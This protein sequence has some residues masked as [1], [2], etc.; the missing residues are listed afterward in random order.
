[1]GDDPDAAA[2]PDAPA[3]VPDGRAR[4][5]GGLATS[6]GAPPGSGPSSTGT[7]YSTTTGGRIG[8]CGAG[9]PARRSSSASTLCSRERR[10]P[11]QAA[12][13]YDYDARFALE[14]Q[15]TNPALASRRRA[16]RALRRAEAAGS[17]GRPARADRGSGVVPARRRAQ[18][19]RRRRG[20]RGRVALLRRGGGLLVLGPRSGFKDRD[21]R[22]A[23]A[24]AAGLARRAGGTRGVGHRQLPR[25]PHG[26]IEGVES[27]AAGAFHGWF[28]ELSLEGRPSVYR[29][30]DT[31]FAGAAAV[32]V[33]AVGAGR[34]VY[35][36][37][38]AT[39]ETLDGLYR[40]LAREAAL[41]VFDVPDGRGA[42]E[43]AQAGI[44][45]GAAGSCSITPTR[46]ATIS[47]PGDAREPPRRRA[48]GRLAR[49]RAYGVAL[50][51][52]ATLVPSIAR[53]RSSQAR[54]RS[55]RSARSASRAPGSST[56]ARTMS[57]TRCRSSAASAASVG[58]GA[59]PRQ[60]RRKFA[61]CACCGS[62]HG[63]SG[64]TRCGSAPPASRVDL[65]PARA[66]HRQRRRRAQPHVSV[67][68]RDEELLVE[69][70]RQPVRRHLDR[71]RDARLALERAEPARDVDKDEPVALADEVTEQVERMDE[72]VDAGRERPKRRRRRRRTRAAAP[73]RETAAVARRRRST[74]AHCRSSRRP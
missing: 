73:R 23:G 13:V 9:R 41:D 32:A 38:V 67:L 46:S 6:A 42:G 53:R 14:I 48:P 5:R 60:T 57:A 16:A 18:P 15:P 37:G 65:D 33:N 17:R 4:S 61:A 25:R 3:H 11:Q 7:A 21:E 19:L 63:S 36:G 70:D 34:V 27:G 58:G 47:I 55:S 45:D 72:L 49:A 71:H 10:P 1:M 8:G 52:P 29:H 50:L 59:S 2:R 39:D 56:R 74:R 30:R 43:A 44:R 26:E 40:W 12:V 24:T 68:E 62:I 22:G 28:E 20:R 54:A 31:D 51:E 35:I 66:I 64:A 69:P